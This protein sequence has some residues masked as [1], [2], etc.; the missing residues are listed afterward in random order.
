MSQKLK[1]CIQ[2]GGLARDLGIRPTDDPVSAI[3][4]YCDR[5]VKTLLDQFSDCNTLTELLDW[6]AARLETVFE[7]AYSDNELQQIKQKYLVRGEKIFAKLEEELSSDSVFGI[8]YKLNTCESWEPHYVSVIDCRGS[9][10][11][12]AYFTKWH[13]IA[14]LLTLTN[15]LRLSF[16]RTHVSVSF[17]SPEEALME[18]IAGHFGFYS[19]IVKNHVRGEISFEA[20]EEVRTRICPGASRQSA[21]IGMVKAW[22]QPCLLVH[23][24]LAL[25]KAEEAEY[26]QESLVPR[27]PALPVLRAVRITVNDLARKEN[28][29]IFENMRV[30]EASIIQCVFRG[31]PYGEAGEDLS[32]W[33]TSS[34]FRL[35]V[36]PVKVKAR[37]SSNFVDALII[38]KD[39]RR[40]KLSSES[41]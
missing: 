1:K 35:P 15:Q 23:A 25:K 27:E 11:L 18:V 29:T 32:W 6:I 10:A 34:G 2:I 8:T 36:Q 5:R 39:S 19:P 31:V 26:N 21:L 41:A 3:L 33:E 37:R 14:H 22:P 30:P 12:R 24:L 13:E 17:D 20:I 38:P 40:R 4:R 16:R 28:L 7:S 9:K